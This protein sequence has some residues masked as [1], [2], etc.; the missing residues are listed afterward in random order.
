MIDNHDIENIKSELSEARRHKAELEEAFKL[1]ES[2]RSK[3]VKLLARG[4]KTS[5]SKTVDDELKEAADAFLMESY[6]VDCLS[7]KVKQMERQNEI[8][9]AG[10]TR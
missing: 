5:P 4:S 7:R 10:Q 6:R 2:S 1:A 9:M 8:E 3:P